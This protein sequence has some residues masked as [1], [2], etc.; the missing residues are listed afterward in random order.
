MLTLYYI[1]KLG[2][3]NTNFSDEETSETIGLIALDIVSDHPC[4]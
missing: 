2:L 1:K 4:S 3:Y